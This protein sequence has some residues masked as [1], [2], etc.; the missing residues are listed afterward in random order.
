M[1]T[2]AAL[3]GPGPSS[4]SRAL[5]Q[6][7]ES[8]HTI[9]R[10]ND[11]LC[12]LLFPKHE[13]LSAVRVSCSFVS[14]LVNACLCLCVSSTMYKWSTSGQVSVECVC[15]CKSLSLSKSSVS[16]VKQSSSLRSSSRP[17]WTGTALAFSA[18]RVIA[19]LRQDTVVNMRVVF[20]R[21]ACTGAARDVFRGQ[22]ETP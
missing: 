17:F 13:W 19:G 14:E 18:V 11:L 7:D 9:V 2:C 21:W 10:R 22:A 8:T 12:A 3:G 6:H 5:S 4:G 16:R 15:Y 20:F 1:P